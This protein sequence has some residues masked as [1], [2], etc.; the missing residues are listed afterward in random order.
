MNR[1]LI[2]ATVVSLAFVPRVALGGQQRTTAVLSGS[3]LDPDRMPVADGV[4]FVTDVASEFSGLVPGLYRVT[5]FTSGFGR[6]DVTLEAG[7]TIRRDIVL[8]FGPRPADD[9]D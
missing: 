1:I 6:V 4:V 5:S 3:I 7:D 8:Q 9:W 2:A